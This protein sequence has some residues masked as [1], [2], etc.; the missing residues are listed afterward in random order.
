[1]SQD[2]SRMRKPKAG[3]LELLSGQW[4]NSRTT[5][6]EKRRRLSRTAAGNREPYTLSGMS[7]G[8][9]YK[10]DRGLDVVSMLKLY[11]LKWITMLGKIFFQIYYRVANTPY[12]VK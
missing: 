11:T 10:S 3:L 1:M 5:F 2:Q 7:G 6:T 9:R 8:T 4:I 12:Y